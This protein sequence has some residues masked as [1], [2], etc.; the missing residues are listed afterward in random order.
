[1]SFYLDKRGRVI[2][3]QNSYVTLLVTGVHSSENQVHFPPSAEEGN[4][5]IKITYLQLLDSPTLC[6]LTIYLYLSIGKPVR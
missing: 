3:R 2:M 6:A 1:M 5:Y 4:T